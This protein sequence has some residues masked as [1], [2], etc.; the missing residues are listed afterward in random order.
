M[1]E[2]EL[3]TTREQEKYLRKEYEEEYGGRIAKELLEEKLAKKKE[4]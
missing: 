1:T 2:E 4:H 3:R